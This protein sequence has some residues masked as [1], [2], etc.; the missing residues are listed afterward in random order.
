[1]TMA[2]YI[3]SVRRAVA[4]P[5]A[6]AYTDSAIQAMIEKYP[7]IDDGHRDPDHAEWVPT[8]DLNAVA[9]DI[10]A[11]KAS[12]TSH[13]YD[14]NADGGSYSWSQ[15][16]EHCMS[17]SRY[18]AARRKPKGSRVIGTTATPVEPWNV[19]ADGDE[20]VFGEDLQ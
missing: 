16:F 14:F 18:Y 19:S 7:V 13:Q 9:A 20:P 11:E 4:E 15:Q 5:T 3:A 6:V 17:M 10:W 1:M 8:Y 2:D 12:A